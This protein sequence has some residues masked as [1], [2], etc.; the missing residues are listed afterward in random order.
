M[1]PV[2]QALRFSREIGK[3]RGIG[4]RTPIFFSRSYFFA[5]ALRQVEL[6]KRNRDSP[7]AANSNSASSASPKS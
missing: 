2:A 6:A 5:P 4:T 7:G 1:Q 3:R